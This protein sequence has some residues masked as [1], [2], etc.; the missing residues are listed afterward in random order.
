MFLHLRLS[1]SLMNI[2]EATQLKVG[3]RKE[4]LIYI[5]NLTIEH[6]SLIPFIGENGSGKTTLLQTFAQH[7]APVKGQLKRLDTDGSTLNSDEIVYLPSNPTFFNKL[8][9]VEH[10]ELVAVMANK[11]V[12]ADTLLKAFELLPFRNCPAFQLSSGQRKCLSLACLAI[13]RPRLILLDE[14]SG[15]LDQPRR[16]LLHRAMYDF[17]Q[18]GSTC[19]FSTH[20]AQ[21]VMIY[22]RALKIE[23]KILSWHDVRTLQPTNESH[24]T[25]AV[26]E[27]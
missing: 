20:H 15:D 5:P 24:E 16:Q 18:K 13:K 2:V 7:I 11:K 27:I 4:T 3:Y 1:I 19:V 17:C 8:S 23:S 21:D 14:P 25:T 12:H 26:S 10:L 22:N 6:G 9:T